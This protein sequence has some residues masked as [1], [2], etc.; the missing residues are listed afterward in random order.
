MTYSVC[1]IYPSHLVAILLHILT[2][3][4]VVN[5]GSKREVSGEKK[6]LGGIF[7]PGSVSVLPFIEFNS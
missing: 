5:M 4:S 6:R 1:Y 2:S 7:F 3:Y